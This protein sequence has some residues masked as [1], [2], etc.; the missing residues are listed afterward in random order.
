M[1]RVKSVAGLLDDYRQTL[2]TMDAH[3]IEHGGQPVEWNQLVDHLQELQLQL[4]ET[5]E[6]RAGISQLLMDDNLTVRQWSASYALA[7]DPELA[8]AELERQVIGGALVG[9]EAEITLREF[10]AGRLNTTWIPKDTGRH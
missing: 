4:R 8:R 2:L 9:F 7:W 10:D 6:G 3:R 1:E 5:V